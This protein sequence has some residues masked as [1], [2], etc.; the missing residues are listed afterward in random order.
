MHQTVDEERVRQALFGQSVKKA[1]GIDKLNFQALRL[2]WKWDAARIVALARQCFR[3]GVHP[4]TW[5]TARGILLRKQDKHD[6]TLVKAYRVISLLN[7]LGKVVEKLA[8]EAIASH[9]EATQALHLGQMGSRRRRSAVDA[10]ACLI[11]RVH[12][13]WA[14]KQLAAALFMDVKGAFDHVSSSKLVERMRELRVDGDL[15]RWTWSFLADRKVQ[16]VI[17]GFQCAEQPVTG[18]PQGSPVSPILFVIYLSGV[19]HAIEETVPGVQALSFADDLGMVVS[20]S[21][22]AQACERLKQAGEA[23]IDWGVQNV[24]QFDAEK[25]EAVLFTRKRGRQLQDQV[26]RAR[27]IIGGKRVQFKQEATRWL[28]IWLDSGLTLKTHYLTRLQKARTAEAR[29]RTLCRTQGLAPGLVR[30]IQ[31]AAIQAT[32]LYGAELWWQGQKDRQRGLQLLINRQARAIT[33]A[34]RSTPIG[35][36]L[37]EAGVGPAEVLLDTRQLE[38]TKRLLGLPES[39]PAHQI[40]PETLRKGDTWAQPGEQDTGDREWATRSCRL[41]SLGQHLARQLARTLPIDPSDGFEEVVEAQPS[42]FPGSIKVL[43]TEKAIDQAQQGRPGLTLWSDGSRLEDGRVGAGVAWKLSQ[44]NWQ[45]REIP[46]GRGKEVFDAELYGACV[47]LEIAQSMLQEGPVTV[48]LDSQA[49]ISRLRHL[50]PGPG[51]ALAARAHQAAQSLQAQ[52]REPTIQWVPG[53]QGIE[54]NERAD[55]AAKRAASKPAHHQADGLTLAFTSRIITE[56][57]EQTRQ[58]WLT[59]ALAKRSGRSQRAYRAGNGWKQDPVVAKAPKRVARRF[60]QLKTGHAAV[61]AFL[62]KIRAQEDASCQGCRAP[63]E[64]VHHLMFECRQWCSQRRILYRDLAKARVQGPTAMEECPEGR[65]FGDSKA[66][67]ALLEFLATTAVG[68]SRGEAIQEVERAQKDEEWGLEVLD[69][70]G[71]DGE[72]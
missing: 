48:L 50:E 15:V 51:Q 41:R 58:A 62:Q 22:V 12:Q 70:E 23:A 26:R 28:G 3:L 59:S 19:F 4:Q 60:Y 6:Y 35:P 10:V 55:Q 33:G 63:N 11:Q 46:L 34:L 43:D 39:N 61:G 69:E 13:E 71:R 44:D 5:K 31:I 14:Q 1:P 18:V 40:L 21:S 9:C 8:A 17:D 53:H 37:R 52:G 16:L 32:A 66:T 67:K 54:G 2:L 45:T 7:C 56:T 64:T 24:V 20:A 47:A 57:Q 49:A 42:S 38:Y 25:T 68:C 36:L 27:I 65:L 30:R 72:G 29:L